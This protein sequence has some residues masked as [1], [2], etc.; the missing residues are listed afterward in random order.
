MSDKKLFAQ[1]VMLLA[2]FFAAL[3]VGRLQATELPARMLLISFPGAHPGLDPTG[4]LEQGYKEFSPF[5]NHTQFTLNFPDAELIKGIEKILSEINR[6]IFVVRT[7]FPLG[8]RQ[9]SP[10]EEIARKEYRADVLK[11]LDVTAQK[12]AGIVKD[13]RKKY[14]DAFIMAI[15]SAAGGEVLMR[16]LKRSVHEI[17][18]IV[19]YYPTMAMV[20]DRQ[21]AGLFAS[22]GYNK[23]SLKIVAYDGDPTISRINKMLD[24]K[25]FDAT[26]YIIITPED[27]KGRPEWA[28]E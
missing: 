16:V 26:F 17:N 25:N 19:L 6:V 24:D 21:F 15:T 5:V 23:D 13:Y 10:P 2:I 12:V 20:L 9:V 11:L 28:V 27:A 7:D 1:F 22:K 14:T 18:Y 4:L 8:L 3:P